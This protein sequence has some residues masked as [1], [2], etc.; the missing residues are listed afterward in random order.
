MGQGTE[1]R[2]EGRC[3]CG[4]VAVRFYTRKSP[5]ALPLRACQCS[6]CRKHGARTTADPEG[7]A[8]IV[9]AHPGAAA[10]YRFALGTAD[11]LVCA[12]CGIYVAAVMTEGEKSYAVLNVNA[13]DDARMFDRPAT[14][15]VYNREDEAARRAR[16]RKLWTPV[17]FVSASS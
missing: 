17:T 15:M 10:R 16:R 9:L 7:R 13:F 6:F 11:Y 8:E 14:P 4:A 5:S 12:R 1:T 2:C 3:H